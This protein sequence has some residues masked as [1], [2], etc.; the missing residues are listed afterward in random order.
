[1]TSFQPADLKLLGDLIQERFGL[2]FEGVRQD[3]LGS[4][5]R[6]RL[7]ELRLDSPRAY[8]EYLR[9][10]P[11]GDAEF[12]RLPALITNNETYFFR[13]TRQF[14]IL[15]EH[16][17]P[18]RRPAAPSRPLRLLSAG[19]SS[20]EEPYSLAIALH[21]AGLP[22]AARSW[23]I[24]ACDLNP[25]RIARAREALYDE[26]SLRAC[27]PESRR[28]YFS[29]E[30]G[31]FRLKDRYRV[32]VRFFQ[33][34]LLAPGF[35]LDRPYDVILCRNLLIYFGDAAFDRLIGL[36]ASALVPGG[37]LFLGHSE[38]LFDRDT[39]LLPVVVGGSVVYRKTA[40]P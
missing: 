25:E 35:A 36:F 33:S 28:R 27:D 19:C 24:D 22:P 9:F 5:L 32:G 29:V 39:E 16:V 34:N 14:E 7:R 8:Y 31:R 37:Y 3:I 4:R 20:G 11:R 21:D 1:M 10:H 2:T 17:L 26:T 40:K 23:E 6:P 30:G 13:E 15:I 38:S 12:D 18:E